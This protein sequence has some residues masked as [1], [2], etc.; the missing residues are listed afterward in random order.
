MKV[1]MLKNK[2]EVSF[3][4]I[5][6]GECFVWNK[7]PYLRVKHTEEAMQEIANVKK[8]IIAGKGLAVNLKTGSVAL[9]S[10]TLPVLPTTMVA[11]E[12]DL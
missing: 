4:R 6:T 7:T 11:Q 3:H 2:D 5:K 12:V 9:F 1:E 8:R 10:D